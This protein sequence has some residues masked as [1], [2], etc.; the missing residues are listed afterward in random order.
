MEVT[1]FVIFSQLKG[2]TSPSPIVYDNITLFE[3][4]ATC[5]QSYEIL[6]ILNLSQTYLFARK[7][8]FFYL[9]AILNLSAHLK[10]NLFHPTVMLNIS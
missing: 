4:I 7:V 8:I 5:Q 3:I 6:I 9:T 10:S 1:E 2:I